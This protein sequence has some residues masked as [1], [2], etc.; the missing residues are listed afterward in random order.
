MAA[1][2]G[3]SIAMQA[4]NALKETI[5]EKGFL[6]TAHNCN[7]KFINTLIEFSKVMK[8]RFQT[9]CPLQKDKF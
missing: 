4:I 1:P 6:N 7:D 9:K 8:A 5:S 2:P 3:Q